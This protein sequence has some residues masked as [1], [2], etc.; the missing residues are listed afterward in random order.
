MQ[1]CNP[2][3]YIYFPLRFWI[4]HPDLKSF[5]PSKN[6]YYTKVAIGTPTQYPPGRIQ[7]LLAIN[8]TPRVRIS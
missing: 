2:H 6:K 3:Y 5:S 4:P 1:F 8:K 7:I